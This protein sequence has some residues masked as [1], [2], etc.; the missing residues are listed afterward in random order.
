MRDI[1]NILN[2]MP[3]D[4][5]NLLGNWDKS[6]SFKHEQDR[7]LL[8]NPKAVA[9]I[10]QQ[11]SKC[12]VPFDMYLVNS[13]E[14]GRHIEIGEVTLDWL[15]ANMPKALKEMTFNDYS[16]T[17]IYTNNN[18]AERVPMTGW[19]LAHRVGH[20]LMS[21]FGG[22]FNNLKDRKVYEY[23][24]AERALAFGVNQIMEC[25][26]YTRPK[27]YDYEAVSEY[28]KILKSLY[29]QLGTFKS[30]R[31]NNLR[32]EFEFLNELVA[33]YIFQGRIKFNVPPD[34]FGHG[35]AVFGRKRHIHIKQEYT[36]PEGRE[37]VA[38]IVEKL[39]NTMDYYLDQ[40]LYNCVGRV[41]VM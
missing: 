37:N 34:S 17:I 5:F 9:K 25:Y 39:A 15:Q 28:D 13:P 22:G 29:H 19:T 7:K 38:Q 41:F 27:T 35:R 2:E 33:Q 21:Y 18:G 23:T 30:A 20:A 1:L 16:V 14:A 26:G 40:M 12:D 6:S 36:T 4:N 11:W 32:E 8:T 3:I 10:K 24:E 31:D